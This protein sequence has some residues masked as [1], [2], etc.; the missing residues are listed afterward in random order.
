MPI[1]E[2]VCGECGARFEKLVRG[3]AQTAPIRCPRCGSEQV[4][5]AISVFGRVGGTATASSSA[6]SSHQCAPSG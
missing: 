2:Y 5:K 6:G 3:S 1:F 4:E